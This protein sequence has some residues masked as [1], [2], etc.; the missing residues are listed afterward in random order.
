MVDRFGGDGVLWGAFVLRFVD[1]DGKTCIVRG[2]KLR[3]AALNAGLIVPTAAEVCEYSLHG[4]RRSCWKNLHIRTSFR[5]RGVEG[6][7]GMPP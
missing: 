1:R 5:R 6:G 4:Y 7:D 3:C 2:S